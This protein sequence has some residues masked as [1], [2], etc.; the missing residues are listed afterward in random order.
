MQQYSFP[1]QLIFNFDE[2]TLDFSAP[3]LKV[4]SRAGSA[5][6]FLEMAEKS[7][8]ISLGLCI[9]ASGQALCPLVILSLKQLPLLSTEVLGFY[10]ISGSDAGF[11]TK[12]IWWKTLNN[13]IIPDIN[14]ICCKSGQ[15]DT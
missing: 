15:L 11:I 12:E 7:E 13:S 5:R 9:S 4:I 14:N 2:T 3:K 8:H 10:A 1:P 6:L